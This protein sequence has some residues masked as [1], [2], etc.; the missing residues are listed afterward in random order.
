MI[1]YNKLQICTLKIMQTCKTIHVHIV[2]FP[3]NC[4]STLTFRNPAGGRKM[5]GMAV[6]RERAL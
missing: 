3:K 5:C 6:R 4:L 1:D 2:D